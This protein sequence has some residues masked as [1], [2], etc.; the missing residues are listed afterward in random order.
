MCLSQSFNDI[1]NNFELLIIYLAKSKI[2][3][4]TVYSPPN[5]SAAQ[6]NSLSTYITGTLDSFLL[7]YPNSKVII[8]GDFN[9]YNTDHLCNLFSLKNMVHIETRGSSIID[10]ILIDNSLTSHYK[11]VYTYPPIATSDHNIVVLQSHEVIN[12]R[13]TK[14]LVTY[15]MRESNMNSFLLL[16]SQSNW[17]SSDITSEEAVIKLHTNLMVS[18]ANSIPAKSVILS[19]NDKAWVSPR[20]KTLFNEKWKAWRRQNFTLYRHYQAKIKEE[21]PK[22]KQYWANHLRDRAK[23]P[24]HLLNEVRNSKRSRFDINQLFKSKEE[25]LLHI[26]ELFNSK[27]GSDST[28]NI[29]SDNIA[30]PVDPITQQE[31]R[32]AAKLMKS[33]SAAGRDNIPSIIYKKA[34]DV[35]SP[36]LQ[37]IYNKCLE[38][39][40]FPKYWKEAVICPVPKIT[41]PTKNDVRPIS[42]L[43]YPSKL[44]ERVIL[45]RIKNDLINKYDTQ[46]YGFRPSS[47][48]SCALISLQKTVSFLL[49]QGSVSSVL[50]IAIDLS[51]AF[52]LVHHDLLL[53]KLKFLHPTYF[54]IIKDFLRDRSQRVRL[55]NNFGVNSRVPSG[56]PQGSSLSPY[57]F[58]IFFADYSPILRRSTVIKYA[59]DATIVLP[60]FKTDDHDSIVDSIKAE[61]DNTNEWCNSNKQ[62]LNLKKVKILNISQTICANINHPIYSPLLVNEMKILGITINNKFNWNSQIF[63]ITTIANQRLYALRRLKNVLKK[64]ELLLLYNGTIR[65]VLEYASVVYPVLSKKLEHKIALVQTRAHNII[66]HKNCRCNSLANLT[67]RRESISFL[68]FKSIVNNTCHPLHHLLLPKSP[69]SSRFILPQCKSNLKLNSFFIHNSIKFNSL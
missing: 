22:A 46:Q 24:W 64:E 33:K 1:Q 44:F 49:D 40:K 23:S 54:N 68:L 65:S 30:V 63:A 55:E 38:E 18:F 20:L 43:P 15:D 7:F 39:G 34:L 16:L 45:S 2:I 36:F 26:T 48:T 32:L 14:N 3:L 31:L 17:A 67:L 5:L 8:N 62:K 60:I 52:D 69:R 66:C 9:N 12:Q 58:S 47:S 35:I 13:N 27:F 50:V 19:T 25:A 28:Y 10:L 11:P 41:P 29:C 56:V 53:T 57:L 37:I 51:A 4:V 21:I 61:I 59:D 42:L 6:K